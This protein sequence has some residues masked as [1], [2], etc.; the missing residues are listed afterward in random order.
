MSPLL[1]LDPCRYLWGYDQDGGRLD[2]VGGLDDAGGAGV[3]VD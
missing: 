1:T 2:E 3:V